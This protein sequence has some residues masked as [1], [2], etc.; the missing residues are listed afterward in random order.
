MSKP[1]R[2]L[3]L[4][5]TRTEISDLLRIVRERFP[6]ATPMPRCH[7][8]LRADYV[9]WLK[10]G[11]KSTTIRLKHGGIDYPQRQQL[12]LIEVDEY[13]S[14]SGTN[15]GNLLIG[16]M[17]IKHFTD[18]TETDALKD[19]FI[20]LAELTRELRRMYGS[21]SHGDFVTIYNVSLQQPPP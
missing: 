21:S 14:E 2:M 8:R 6:E 5:L 9:E 18:L 12:P 10:Q 3:T 1:N 16:Q 20:S 19:G 17:V 7:F 11:R 13:V 4:D 15:L